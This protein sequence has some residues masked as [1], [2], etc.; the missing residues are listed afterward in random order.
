MIAKGFGD[1]PDGVNRWQ[2]W[3]DVEKSKA[4]RKK[5]TSGPKGRIILPD[6]VRAEARTYQPAP[7]SPYLPSRAISIVFFRSL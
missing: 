6:Y 1:I 4:E 7:T 2:S 5:L 3:P